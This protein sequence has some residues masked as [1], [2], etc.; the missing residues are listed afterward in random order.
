M[1]RK[2]KPL[3][4][5]Q[6]EQKRVKSRLYY[7]KNQA[8]VL[9]K[10]RKHYAENKESKL[11]KQKAFRDANKET[12][13]E[14]QRQYRL[15]N[16]KKVR[17]SESKSK[18]KAQKNQPEKFAALASRHRAQKAKLFWADEF[19]ILEIYDLAKRRTRLTGI[20][21]E[22]D[23]IVPLNS[24][25]VCGLHVHTNLR[26]IPK[27]LNVSKNNRSWPNHP[28]PSRSIDPSLFCF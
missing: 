20:K 21:W 13:L 1:A 24:V 8:L 16:L 7:E 15:A 2:R 4:P 6:L 26:V 9:E 27:V 10:Q 25:L 14:K 18:A 11:I 22:V 28:N 3:T 19:L 12:V 5:E 17:A 23:H